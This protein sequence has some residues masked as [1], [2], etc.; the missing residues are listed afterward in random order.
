[1]KPCAFAYHAPT[2]I[3]EAAQ[4]LAGQDNARVLAG[5]QSLVPM[6]NFRYVLPDMLVD[7]N[8]V[9]ELDGV[10]VHPD[11]IEIGACTRQRALEFSDDIK[12]LCPLMAEAIPHIGHR[13]TRNR[14]TIGGSI[15]HADPAAELPA[16]A[17]AHDATLHVQSGRGTRSISMGDFV[18]GFMMTAL[19][20]D[21]ILTRIT[22]PLW[23][24]GHGYA[25]QEFAR[26]R[27]DFALAAVAV[28]L[29]LNAGGAIERA[30]ITLAGVGSR[31]VR[32]PEGERVL[33]GQMPSR[34]LFAEAAAH[35]AKAEA[36]SDIHAA[37]DYRQHLARVLTGRALV[38]AHAKA[39][40][41]A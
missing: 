39:Q 15:A 18:Q 24:K 6:M 26:R 2:T 34:E 10:A 23:P 36:T 28:L 37:A 14:G 11:R 31:P 4:L 13:Q 30:S 7:V 9:R 21:E 1:M 29:Q 5:G 27:G 3:A 16:I 32:V 8:N 41:H 12:R 25:F 17:L 33:V 20:P 40:G 22:L 38:A 19:E 35:S